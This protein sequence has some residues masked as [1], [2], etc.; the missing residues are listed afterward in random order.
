MV[1]ALS[2]FVV[3][4]N[5]AKAT[6]DEDAAKEILAATVKFRD[7]HA[8]RFIELG[9]RFERFDVTKV[10]TVESLT[11][12]ESETTARIALANYRALLAERRALLQA[13]IV[14]YE[15]FV[16]DRAP[17][18]KFR[19]GMTAAFDQKKA[20]L[21]AFY[22]GLDD[23]GSAFANSMER[24]LNWGALQRVRMQTRNGALIFA[25]AGQQSEYS[26]LFAAMKEAAQRLAVTE[27][28]AGDV[29]RKAQEDMTQMN[30]AV[31]QVLKK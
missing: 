19:A 7:E 25:D 10:V 28:A 22:W 15:R 9:Q 30:K 23:A 26:A 24:M 29:Q 5:V 13:Y 18:E 8:P 17:T 14:E 4:G 11:T 16:T 2:C 3:W 31:E 27:R 12:Q 1:G 21:V 6:S 20:A